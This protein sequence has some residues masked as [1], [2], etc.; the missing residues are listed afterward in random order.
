MLTKLN[1]D[2]AHSLEE[3]V[4]S[5][6][7]NTMLSKLEQTSFNLPSGFHSSQGELPRPFQNLKAHS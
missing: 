3:T 6:S 5:R 4:Y 2:V 1:I 7:Q